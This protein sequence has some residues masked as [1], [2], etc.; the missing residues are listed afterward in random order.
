M[1][2]V[3]TCALPIY[4][5]ANDGRVDLASSGQETMPSE[6]DWT[7]KEMAILPTSAVQQKA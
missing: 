7:G 1:T 3:Q 5:N 2:G 4:E 6:Q